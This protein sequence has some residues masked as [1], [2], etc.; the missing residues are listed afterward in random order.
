M[1]VTIKA[2]QGRGKTTLAKFIIDQ[3]RTAGRI[4]CVTEV[5]E[6]HPDTAALIFESHP[7]AVIFDGCIINTITQRKAERLISSYRDTA[8]RDVLAIYILQE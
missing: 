7:D 4:K 8:K 3:A 1:D 6:L 2:G 5:G